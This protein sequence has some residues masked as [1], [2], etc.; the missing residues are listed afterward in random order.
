M[1]DSSLIPTTMKLQV[2]I[3]MLEMIIKIGKYLPYIVFAFATV[4]LTL[5][6]LDF[7]I[8]NSWAFGV[9]NTIL[10]VG[11]FVFTGQ[12]Y[13]RHNID[14]KEYLTERKH[15]TVTVSK[16][17]EQLTPRMITLD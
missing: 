6:I 2:V 3:G 12:L 7:T 5:A 4:N 16:D 11:G 15:E 9:L 14:R 8:W 13:Q 1:S 10:A 17:P